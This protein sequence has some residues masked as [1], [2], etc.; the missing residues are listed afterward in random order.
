MTW[1]WDD[2]ATNKTLKYNEV[3]A[4]IIIGGRSDPATQTPR[5]H[6]PTTR[7]ITFN[8]DES[9]FFFFSF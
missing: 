3:L 1:I 5:N 6:A 2:L 9:I 7:P 8:A 4:Q